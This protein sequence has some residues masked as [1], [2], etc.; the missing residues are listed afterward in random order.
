MRAGGATMP[1]MR[2]L[3]VACLLVVAV[4]KRRLSYRGDLL[5]QGLDEIMRGLLAFALLEVYVSKGGALA[6]WDHAQLLFVLGFSLVPIALFHTFCGNL[7]SLSSTYI[8]QGNLD[9]VLLRP[10]PVFLQVC[11]DRLS[12]EDLGGALLGLLLMG[13]AAARIPAFDWSPGHLLLLTAMLLS[14]FLVVV[15]V[16]QAFAAT[17]FW[18]EDRVGMVPP[19]Y[20]LME[21]G[22]WPPSIYPAW[23]KWLLTCV[24]PF[25]FVATYPA[26]VF[27]GATGW[28]PGLATPAVALAALLASNWLW[29]KGLSRY[30]SAGS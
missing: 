30:N 13:A 5:L 23:L 1:A 25:G 28:W 22:R 18:F 26:G 4:L 10:Y 2:L 9:R 7:Y 8:I 14:S 17:G 16:F 3:R 29:R 19:V 15:A 12:I 6:G 21:L 27:T 20:N 24:I 11:F